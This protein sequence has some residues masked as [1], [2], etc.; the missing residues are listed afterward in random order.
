MRHKF[1]VG[2]LTVLL[3]GCQPAEEAAVAPPKPRP[4]KVSTVTKI[5]EGTEYSYPATV[6][7]SQVAELSF[8]VGGQI[9]DLPVLA[10][11]EVKKGALIA[12]LDPRDFESSV[13]QLKSQIVAEESR[14]KA[15]TSGARQEDIAS[16]RSAVEAAQARVSSA[17]SQ[18][19]RTLTQY[20]KGLV[21]KEQMDAELAAVKSAQ[22]QLAADQQALSKGRSGSRSEDVKAQE[23]AIRT[24]KTQLE[25]AQDT[26][27]DTTLEAPF[28]GIIAER[29]VD[30]FA[31]VQ[32]KQVI[33]VIQNLGMLELSFNIPGPDVARLGPNRDSLLLEA[34]LD[35]VPDRR[36]PARLEEFNTQA[37]PQTRTFEARV[38]IERPEDYSILPGMVGQVFVTDTTRANQ[39]LGIPSMALGA[40]S[41][42][43][44]IVWVVN[45]NNTVEMRQVELGEIRNGQIEI[46]SGVREGEVIVSAG[47]SLMTPGLEIRPINQIGE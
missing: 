16:L 24:L 29:K 3:A 12:R 6:L 30:N 11:S 40:D 47:V 34:K 18:A 21:A 17:R 4:V 31:N 27:Q 13:E 37:D 7:S 32:A 5:S 41:E 25:N 38:A 43:R 28:D 10:M 26:R 20:R 2:L 45:D 46:R 35:A 39:T 9:I 42:S 36:F 14:L 23:A 19:E 22:A 33:A 44:P 8:R 1:A 15:M